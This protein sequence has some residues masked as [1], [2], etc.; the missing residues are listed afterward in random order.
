MADDTPK[1]WWGRLL[2]D[3]TTE[4][5][6]AEDPSVTRGM[7]TAAAWSWRILVV[8]AAVALLIFIIVQLRLI[9]IPLLI[10]ILVSALL[11]PVVSFL[12]RH[13]W[14]R[15]LAVAAAM[16]GAIAVVSGLLYLAISQ[17]YAQ[18]DS[19]KDRSLGAFDDFKQFLLDSPMHITEA[20]L[21]DFVGQVWNS[22]QEDGQVLV[23]GAL[24]LGSTLGHVATG[25]FLSLFCLLFIL[26][27]GKTIW[28]WTV[29]V[30][31]KRARPAVDGAGQ[32]GWTTLGNY[33]RTQILVATIDAV[34]IGLGAF[35]LG[36]PLAIPV[37]VL[38]LLGSFVPIIGAVVTG[39]VAVFLA[40]VYNGPFIALLMLI[41]VLAVQQIEGHVLQPLIMGTA[42][43]VHPLAVVLAVAGGTMVAG[44][45]GALFAV[46]VVAVFNV[47]VHY[48][49]SGVWR[50]PDALPAAFSVDGIWHTVPA[51]RPGSKKA[52]VP[53]PH[54]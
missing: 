21:N 31:P 15:G 52:Q 50:T 30:F 1:T 46:P 35:L 49:S 27:D 39:A 16:L 3:P 10:A 29:R 2:P 8:A 36:V 17:I 32:A 33:A 18:F 40:L 23:S 25:L 42:V 13:R 53:D 43:K 26:I 11:T 7:R 9:V 6:P 12:V 51:H 20:Q 28:R 19:V 14:P 45:P 47:M 38:V 24:S 44:I 48:I 5:R 34:G 4:R 22:V 41:V 37:A 54:D